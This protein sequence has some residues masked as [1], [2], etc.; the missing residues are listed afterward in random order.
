MEDQ[1]LVVRN[2][3]YGALMWVNFG[4]KNSGV[5]FLRTVFNRCST[6]LRVVSSIDFTKRSISM[7]S[8]HVE[9]AH[10]RIVGHPLPVCPNAGVH[11]SC[12]RSFRQSDITT[13]QNDA[14]RE[15]LEV[16]FPR[17]WQSFVEVAKTFFAEPL[18]CRIRSTRARAMLFATSSE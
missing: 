15:P 3:R 9:R 7:T 17:P 6:R 18:V 8:Y 11:S 10:F 1:R 14:G 5:F 2:Y 16:P 4:N 13:G 12:R